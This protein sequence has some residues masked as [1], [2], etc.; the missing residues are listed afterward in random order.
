MTTQAWTVDRFEEAASKMQAAN[1]TL[2]IYGD[3]EGVWLVKD[4][5]DYGILVLAVDGRAVEAMKDGVC[6]C[7]RPTEFAVGWQTVET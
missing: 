7:T 4:G 1:Q 2:C 6:F 5:T 3:A